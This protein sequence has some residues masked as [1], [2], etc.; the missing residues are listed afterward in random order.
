MRNFILVL[1]LGVSFSVFSQTENDSVLI[2]RVELERVFNSIDTLTIQDSIKTELINEFT[3]QLKNYE[4]LTNQDS[5]L[6]MYQ[7]R[8]INLLNTEIQLYD[9]RLKH[10]DKWYRKP[11]VGFVVGVATISTSSWIVS[12]IK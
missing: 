12:N 10:V 1:L 7:N 2:P 6:L 4:M 3:L 5:I 9:D 11:W 8:Q